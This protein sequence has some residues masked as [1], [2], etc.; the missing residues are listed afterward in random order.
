M[1]GNVLKPDKSDPAWSW[2]ALSLNSGIGYKNI[3][4]LIEQLCSS[5]EELLKTVTFKKFSILKPTP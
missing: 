1:T 2:L 4:E 3:R 5:V